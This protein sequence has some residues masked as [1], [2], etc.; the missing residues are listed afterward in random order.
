[1]VEIHSIIGLLQVRPSRIPGDGDLISSERQ[2]GKRGTSR[3]A[4]ERGRHPVSDRINP[5]SDNIP[6]AVS[7]IRIRTFSG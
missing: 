5:C 1:M 4:W 2:T 6:I 3:W 7:F